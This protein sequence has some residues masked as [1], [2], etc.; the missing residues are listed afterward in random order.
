MMMQIKTTDG[1]MVEIDM[2]E[3]RRIYHEVRKRMPAQRQEH[4]IPGNAE[5]YAAKTHEVMTDAQKELR[6]ATGDYP[7]DLEELYEFAAKHRLFGGRRDTH[8]FCNFMKLFFCLMQ[9]ETHEA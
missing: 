1:S 9:K 7:E 4:H 6:K 2:E 5:G 8:I 3:A